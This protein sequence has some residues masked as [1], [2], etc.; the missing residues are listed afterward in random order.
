LRKT[1]QW[2]SGIVRLGDPM[3]PLIGMF[4][5]RSAHR[6]YKG[7]QTMIE[8]FGSPA[9]ILRCGETGFHLLE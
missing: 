3:D 5:G 8:L 6:A 1:V 9:N 7:V 2:L 4:Q